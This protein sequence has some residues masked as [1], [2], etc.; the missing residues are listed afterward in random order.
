MHQP[1]RGAVSAPG[2][3]YRLLPAA[4][5]PALASLWTFGRRKPLGAAGLFLILLLTLMAVF[6][7][8]VATHDPEAAIVREGLRTPSFAPLLGTDGLGRDVFSR[9]VYG[10]QASLY[11]GLVAVALGTAFGSLFGLLSG[12]FGGRFDF[13]LQRVMDM[14]MAFPMI[15]L[16]LAILSALGSSLFNV[17]LALS[18]VLAPS[19][20]RVVRSSVLT[21]RENQYVEA[22]R[23]IG[24]GHSRILLLHILPNVA[25]PIIVLASIPLGLAILVEASLSFL[26]LGPPP[27]T[28]TWGGMLSIEGRRFFER[29]WWLAVFPGLAISLAVLSFNL[30]GDALREVWDPRLR[31]TR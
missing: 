24:C 18:V 1:R 14:L 19:A 13:A 26:G 20:N 21:V 27:P 29:A 12:Y 28:P 4:F 6:A 7:P 3:S 10:A 23:A 30:F 11:V 31:G 15:V 17:I 22:A 2:R 16:A 5:F 8:L 25:A 9:I